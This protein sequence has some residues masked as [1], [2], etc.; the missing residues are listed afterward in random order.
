MG[1]IKIS[2][3][4]RG[5]KI[6]RLEKPAADRFQ[7]YFGY[8]PFDGEYDAETSYIPTALLRRIVNLKESGLTPVEF[9]VCYALAATVYSERKRKKAEISYSELSKW[10]QVPVKRLPAIVEKLQSAGFLRLA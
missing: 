5:G 3:L 10:T 9:Q 4:R 1:K 2:A 6:T 8:K 7:V